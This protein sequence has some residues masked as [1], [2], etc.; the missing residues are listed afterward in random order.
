MLATNHPP[1]VWDHDLP[2]G[3]VSELVR[4]GRGVALDLE[5]S[6]LE[7]RSDKIATVQVAGTENGIAHVVR[8]NGE[9]PG[10]L[11]TD[12][13]AA[14]PKLLHHAMFNLRFIGH[15]WR[16][17]PVN[18]SCT[19]IAS[20]LLRPADSDHSLKTL[21]FRYLR[22][23]ADKRLQTSNWFAE[24]LSPEQ[25]AYAVGDVIHLHGLME[26]LMEELGGRCLTDLAR[27]CFDHIPT[28]V[29]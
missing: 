3:A 7:W 5:T 15:V 23:T 19:K 21:L 20:K 6:G 8:M 14:D 10:N 11:A 1:R 18:V 27:R 2:D 29:A 22:I 24:A 9:V 4:Q 26:A 25:I 16:I 28:R 12:Y 17:A 13:R